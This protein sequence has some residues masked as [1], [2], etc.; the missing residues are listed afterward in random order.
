MTNQKP[1]P[2]KCNPMVKSNR[3][4]AFEL[5]VKPGILATTMSH[6]I[7]PYWNSG[8]FCT[9]DWGDGNKEDAVKSGTKLNHTYAVAGTYT[10]KI[11]AYCYQV[12]IAGWN[13]YPI[14]DSCSGNWNE[15][16]EL[17]DGGIMFYNC[18]NMKIK[19]LELPEK[20]T[21]GSN[22][23]YRCSNAQL[24]LTKLPDGLKNGNRMFEG[25][26]NAQL[27]LTN[28]P[29]GISNVSSM[30]SGCKN[31]LLPLTALPDSI[32][33]G[34]AMFGGCANATLPLT[35]LPEGLKTGT[36]MFRGCTNA[37]LHLTK[38]PDSITDGTTMF[39]GCTNA[40]LHL[41]KLP[42][43]LKAGTE[44]FANCVNAEIN[45]DTLVANAPAEGW[46]AL[47]NISNMFSGA[48]KVT[49]SR[50]AFLAKCPNVT[51]QTNTFIGTNTT[52]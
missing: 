48:S 27:P 15:L 10:I 31:A 39:R 49:G 14:V 36:A 2:Y 35:K 50:S 45:L 47:T 3:P 12:T 1:T 18:T 5:V 6:G 13:T 19:C 41:T 21:N 34:T 52:A 8:G 29:E 26:T 9:V 43:G 28:L 51:A 22:M 46:T 7:I 16:G 40:Q 4:Q 38:L 23:F 17:T 20:L 42:E 33:D 44:M 30:F 25:C 24:P 32:T 37:Q 11:K